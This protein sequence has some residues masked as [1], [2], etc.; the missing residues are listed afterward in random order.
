MRVR[1]WVEHQLIRCPSLVG[2]RLWLVQ[3][4]VPVTPLCRGVGG[5]GG[6]NVGVGGCW[7]VSGTL[8]GPERPHCSGRLPAGGWLVGGVFLG[9]LRLV[10]KL[11]PVSALLGWVW[12]GGCGRW[13]VV[14]LVC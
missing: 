12:V 1:S 9:G 3:L 8:L 6:G 14:L 11:L 5:V 13:G 4:P 10:R 2:A 7:W